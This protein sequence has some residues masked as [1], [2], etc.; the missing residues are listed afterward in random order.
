[1]TWQHLIGIA[2]FNPTGYLVSALSNAA[3][4]LGYWRGK[5]A[6]ALGVDPRPR[7]VAKRTEV[8]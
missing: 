1:M 7:A 8:A 4:W 5:R 2:V 6:S 3:F